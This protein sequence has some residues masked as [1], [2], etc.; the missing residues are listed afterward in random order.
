MFYKTKLEDSLHYR[1]QEYDRIVS[2][3]KKYKEAFIKQ[4]SYEPNILELKFD[5]MT[6]LS[7]FRSILALV[8]G[9]GDI[10]DAPL[11]GMKIEIGTHMAVRYDSDVGQD[12]HLMMFDM[13]LQDT[14]TQ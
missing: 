2:V 7:E 14:L 5:E 11:L 10:K 9:R 3:A 8:N 12:E 13:E 1:K 4:H 6:R